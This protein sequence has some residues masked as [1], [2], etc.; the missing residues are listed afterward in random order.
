MSSG[1]V[2]GACAAREHSFPDAIVRRV[3]RG[4]CSHRW[5][6]SVVGQ[7]V[8]L[9]AVC[10]HT[11]AHAH[12]GALRVDSFHPPSH[13]GELFV[14]GFGAVRTPRPTFKACPPPSPVGCAGWFA[15]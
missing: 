4:V 13:Q 15:R 10:P 7:N 6:G 5:C 11:A 1:R 3:S 9:R 8:E 2:N 12:H 14:N